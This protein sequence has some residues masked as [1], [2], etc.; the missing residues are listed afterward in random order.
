MTL[1]EAMIHDEGACQQKEALYRQQVTI[2]QQRMDKQI[3]TLISRAE[4]M[5]TV[6]SELVFRI[7]ELRGQFIT[8]VCFCY[9]YIIYFLM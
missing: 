1:Q 3:P 9:K 7:Q 2:L 4:K 8:S 6:K 5:D